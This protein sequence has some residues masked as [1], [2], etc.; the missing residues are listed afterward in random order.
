MKK[1]VLLFVI[2]CLFLGCNDL[3]LKEGMNQTSYQVHEEAKIDHFNIVMTDYHI[4]D[5]WNQQ[6]PVHDQF[7]IVE[8]EIENKDKQVSTIYANTS[9]QLSINQEIYPNLSLE[10]QLIIPSKEKKKYTVVYDVPKEEEYHILFYSGI[11]TNN[12]EFRI[13][14]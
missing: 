10:S 9:Y 8:F 2:S 5:H 7:L 12:I 6:I 1:I 11:V 4:T 13:I 3:S 14:I